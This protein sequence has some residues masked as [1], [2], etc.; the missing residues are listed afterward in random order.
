MQLELP[1]NFYYHVQAAIAQGIGEGL[2]NVEL[3]RM[4]QAGWRACVDH[5]IKPD[6]PCPVCALR[7]AECALREAEELLLKIIPLI[8][9]F[10]NDKARN[11]KIANYDYLKYRGPWA[12]KLAVLNKANEAEQHE[13]K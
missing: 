1:P 13:G 7:E 5:I 12:E 9:D 11:P 6:S 8:P 4:R 3:E 2:G 10:R